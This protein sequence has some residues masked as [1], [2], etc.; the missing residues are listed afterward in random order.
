M[1]LPHSSS[2]ASRQG[3]TQRIARICHSPR[4]VKVLPVVLSVGRQLFG[5]WAQPLV[6]GCPMAER[7]ANPCTSSPP[8][9]ATSSGVQAWALPLAVPMRRNSSGSSGS[10]GLPLFLECLFASSTRDPVARL[11]PMA[12]ACGES[13]AGAA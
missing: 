11:P 6:Y 12:E 3:S 8:L 2:S 5:V 10:A 4:R 1:W 13:T 7:A 9:N